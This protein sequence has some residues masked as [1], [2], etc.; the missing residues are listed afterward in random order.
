MIAVDVLSL[1]GL[2]EDERTKLAER[3]DKLE[4]L[5]LVTLGSPLTHLY[6]YYFPER[7]PPLANDS[8]GGLRKTVRN[9]VNVY[10]VDDFVG[11]YIEK[12]SIPGWPGAPK[13]VPIAAGGHTGYWRQREVVTMTGSGSRRPSDRGEVAT[14]R[15]AATRAVHD[16]II[17]KQRFPG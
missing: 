6:Q 10:R 14:V 2:D 4:A 13:N 3:L 8:W 17:L 11:T 9:W 1:C 5:H 12:Q 15:S 7:Y 16:Y